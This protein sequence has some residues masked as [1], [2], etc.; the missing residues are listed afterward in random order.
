LDDLGKD[1]E[2]LDKILAGEIDSYSVEKRYVKKDYSQV[3]VSLT[4]SLV[5]K[6]SGIQS[7]SSR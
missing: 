5:R 6:L 2:H 7:T 1:L 4:V 3:W